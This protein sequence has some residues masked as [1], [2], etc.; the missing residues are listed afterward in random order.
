MS[1]YDEIQQKCSP[2]LIASRD[3]NA[4]ANQVNIGRK[5]DTNKLIGDGEILDLLDMSVANN[6]LDAIYNNTEFRYAKK[7]LDNGALNTSSGKVR[8]IVPAYVPAILTQQEADLLLALG[9]ED[10]FVTAEQIASSIDW[11]AV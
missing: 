6:F 11:S 3:F 10:D 9:Y 1:L 7:L 4:I 2:E 8:S 5:K